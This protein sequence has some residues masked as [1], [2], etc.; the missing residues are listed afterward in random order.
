M[1]RTGNTSF[2]P[3]IGIVTAGTSK[4]GFGPVWASAE[5]LAAVVPA[6]ASAPVAN[7]VLRSPVSIRVLRF[8]LDFVELS[9]AQ[10]LGPASRLSLLGMKKA[11]E[12][13]GLC[14]HMKISSPLDVGWQLAAVRRQLGH[15]LLV[16]PDI[17]A[18]G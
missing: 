15:H 12:N 1:R 14:H 6:S 18:R 9:T 13:A 4:I 17:H 3:A 10:R 11:R 7:K 2:S 8:V 5:R 16:Q